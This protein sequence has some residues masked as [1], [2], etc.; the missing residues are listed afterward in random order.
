MGESVSGEK[1]KRG[2]RREG[3]EVNKREKQREECKF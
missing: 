3:E 2:K 1:R